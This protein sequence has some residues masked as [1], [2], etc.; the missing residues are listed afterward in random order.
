MVVRASPDRRAGPRATRAHSLPIRTAPPGVTDRP[1]AREDVLDL[2]EGRVEAQQ[3]EHPVDPRLRLG[4]H[5]AGHRVRCTE[6]VGGG[7]ARSVGA[8]TLRGAEDDRLPVGV[9]A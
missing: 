4:A 7:R 9:D 6:H 5:E 2:I 1:G 3:V 8:S